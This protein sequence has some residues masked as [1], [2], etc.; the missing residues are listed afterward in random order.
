[1]NRLRTFPLGPLLLFISAHQLAATTVVLVV[2]PSG[3]V[4][5]ADG[6][7]NPTGTAT[8][9]FLLKNRL[10]VA[11]LYAETAKT[12]DGTAT[13]YDFPFW[14]KQIDSCTSPEVSVSEV[15][16]IIRDKIRSAFAFAIDAI[17]R[18]EMTKEQALT[19]GIDAY[20]DQFII[21]GYEKV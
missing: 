7:T 12:P 8:K 4:V 15:T 6:K 18:G 1:M 5:G 2:T 17:R 3:M 9:I 19:Q 21:A 14:I 11:D 20:L 10:A 13:L 16:K